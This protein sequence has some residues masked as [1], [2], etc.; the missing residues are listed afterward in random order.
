MDPIT[1]TV[2]QRLTDLTYDR[3]ETNEK[4][5]S[6]QE[7]DA[8]QHG[9]HMTL[10]CVKKRVYVPTKGMFHTPRP[11]RPVSL[12][13]LITLGY[14]SES[15]VLPGGHVDE[16]RRS[17][18]E[19]QFLANRP[20]SAPSRPTRRPIRVLPLV[21]RPQ[22]VRGSSAHVHRVHLRRDVQGTDRV[23]MRLVLDT[24][25]IC[26]TNA[27]DHAVVPCFHMCVCIECSRRIQQCPMC[28]G[29]VDRIQRIFI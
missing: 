29:S 21:S 6:L 16:S 15:D 27:K 13:E 22:T 12:A 17:H 24:C 7:N 11:P 2:T 19:H 5:P 18:A 3:H 10:V 26:Y 14:L 8:F 1:L 23:P 25:C 20:R 4:S 9:T 28:R